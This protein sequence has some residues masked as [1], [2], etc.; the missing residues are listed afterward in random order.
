VIDRAQPAVTV[1]FNRA[2]RDPD[3]PDDA[4]LPAATL[5]ADQ[6]KP[7]L[8]AWRW[9]GTHGMMF[10]P[11]GVLPGAT[12]FAV[13]VPQ[14]AKSVEGEVLGADY[15]FEFRTDAPAVV[16]TLPVEGTTVKPD[17]TFV[18]A[19][20]QPM[21][22]AAIEKGVRVV[23]RPSASDPGR[24]VPFTAK[25]AA[26]PKDAI[27]ITPGVPL[28]LDSAVDV[29][30]DA[31]LRGEGALLA[32]APRTLSFRTY[33]P[34]R[35]ADIVCPRTSGGGRCQAHRDFTIVLSN[36]VAAEEFAAH[37]KIPGLPRHK[38]A[39]TERTTRPQGPSRE[40]LVLA[41]PDFGKRYH[42]VLTAGMRD[43][44]GQRLERDV[45]FDIDIEAPFTL[46]GQ[47]VAAPAQKGP[48]P[49]Y[50]TN[51]DEAENGDGA[52]DDGQPDTHRPRREQLQYG[53]QVG[54]TGYVLE[55]NARTGLKSHQVPVGS[56][57]IPTYAMAAAR[58]RQED[59]LSWIARADASGHAMQWPWTWVTPSAPENVRAVRTVDLDALLG[60]T[61]SHGS[62]LL[63]TAMPGSMQSPDSHVV[64]I[65]DL[66]ISARVSRYGTLV[67]VTRLSTG[68]PVA[69]ATVTIEALGKAPLF[70]G[71][72][73]ADGVLTIPA[74]QWSPMKDGAL[75]SRAVI[76][77]R[78]GDDWTFK[79]MSRAAASY[80]GVEVDLLQKADW[81][82]MIYTDRGV[83][84]PG[85]VLKLAGVFRKANAEG[86]KVVNADA[87][88]SFEDGQGE[89]VF[90][91]RADL[92][93]YGE[94]S[95]EL[96][97]P[98]TT[99]LGG[100]TVHVQI[101][102]D[103]EDRFDQSV[104]V[105]AY[106]ASEFKVEVDADRK[107]YVRGDRAKF[108]VHAEYL[109]GAP[110]ARAPL[111]TNAT[112]G[113]A[114]FVPPHSEGWVV[115]DEA[116][117]VD[118]P[119]TNA[120]AGELRAEEGLKLDE[121]GRVST[122]VG[123]DLPRMRSPETVLFEAEV[124]DVTN[125]T[126]AQRT[127]VLVHPAA[128]YV[129]LGRM[130]T[131]FVSVGAD[132]AVK[133]AAI[134]PSG[135]HVPDA[136]V[137]V[138]L[139]HR[140]WTTVIEDGPP[141]HPPHRRSRVVDDVVGH[142]DVV[143]TK[144]SGSC[145]LHVAQ[146]G[147]Y[148]VRS[149]AKDAAGNETG[150]SM[151]FYCV[152]DQADEKTTTVAWAD[153]D[154]RDL[155]LE[156][157]KRQYDANDV[158]RILV[159]NPFREAEALVT[160]ERAGVLWSKVTQLK[161][162]MPIVEVP[163]RSDYFPNAFVAV[164]LV[165]GRVQAP[166]DTGADVGGP[167]YRLGVLPIHVNP[168]THRLTIDVR[169]D[170]K[171]Y[172]PGDELDADV[173]VSVKDGKAPSSEVT[174]YAVDEGVL[175]LTAYKTPDPLPPF[176]VQRSLAV[177]PLESRESLARLIAMKNG[178]R[179]K[180]LGWEYLASA[181]EDKGSDGGGGD[182]DSPAGAGP[183]A[184]FRT[185]AFFQAG[186]V[187]SGEGNE[188]HAR[189]HFKLPDNL[190][191]FRLMAIAAS[192]DRFGAGETSITSSKHLMARPA[193]PRV[194]RVGDTFDATVVVSS[195]GM[196]P[197]LE[198]EVTLAAKGVRVIGPARKHVTLRGPSAEVHFP[199]KAEAPGEASFEMAV[200]GAGERDRV[201]VKRQVELPVAAR[202][203]AA[204]GETT[205]GAAVQLGDL[206]NARTDA[207]SGGGL[208]VHVASTAL[209]GLKTSFDRAID[210]P[211]GC[212][213]QLT[214]RVLPLLVL[215]E[216]ASLYGVRMPA[217]VADVVDDA[218]GQILTH[219]RPSGGFGFWEDDS[220]VVPWLSAYAMLAVETAGKKGFFVPK[221]ARDSGI[222]YLRRTLDSSRIE[223]TDEGDDTQLQTHA[224]ED[225]DKPATEKKARPYPTLAF[226]ADVLATLGLPD[227]GYLNRLYDARAHEPLFS[228]ALLLHAMA[229]A[230]MPRP[231]I[232]ILE[233]EVVARVR[234]TDSA[235]YVDDP[236]PGWEFLLDSSARTAAMV[237]RGI[238]AASPKD[239]LA[240]RLAK[241][242]LAHR[243][244]GAWRSTQ[245]NVWA[246]LALDDYRRAQE[247]TP[248]D[249]QA[250]VFLGDERI[251]EAAFHGFTVLDQLFTADMAR[252]VAAP[253][254]LS[255]D[256]Q[257]QGKLYYEAELR[258]ATTD[259]PEKARDR[260]FFV[261]KLVRAVAPAD[262]RAATKVLPPRSDAQ[263]PA[264]K[265][266]LVDLLLESA[267]P[268]EQVVVADPLPG[269]IE[270]VDFALDTSAVGDR[271]SLD[272]HELR[273]DRKEGYGAFKEAPGMHREMHDDQVLTFLPHLEPGIYHLHYLAR[274][275]T[276]GT[277]V[278]PP[279]RAQA[280][281]SPEV[282]GETAATQFAVTEKQ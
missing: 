185:T 169:T 177:F 100:G 245:E 168:D 204:Y 232:D 65:T 172:R 58:I 52:S 133:V 17:S 271:I 26:R 9:V 6:D 239:P 29:T 141:G 200:A 13:T 272:P 203:V 14:G 80:R 176:T 53:V 41:D 23:A 59:V 97:L 64:S 160:V 56:V 139:V 211:Y 202:T 228:Q 279:T 77:A 213:E 99:H 88:V 158:A 33:G 84:R 165:R 34:L 71:T 234:S 92:D 125:Q 153:P 108:D 173:V 35:L 264:G 69:D 263:A 235:A 86:L 36:P 191:T 63:A 258:Y 18:L 102:R 257:G 21:D 40:Q 195:K 159:R 114:Y 236:E 249:F 267:E 78:S 171:E 276:Q 274:A 32:K 74:D 54:L 218:V 122:S 216:M 2:M 278:V 163:V 48:A 117:V 10:L 164:H 66:A 96:P 109:F 269:G 226:A 89:K 94:L 129:G 181:G 91:G 130:Q 237:L 273:T 265:L 123:L 155:K 240:E 113:R 186:Q 135:A 182:D 4:G 81:A 46:A 93:A 224:D 149:R 167:E 162:P 280:M 260:G 188:G 31:G 11:A 60:G 119:E 174:F 30:V 76:F 50:M 152:D 192:G 241:G 15:H 256:V 157:D 39:A 266:V 238:V 120:S 261:R 47:P 107:E 7:V 194:V 206:K 128:F 222:E 229:A 247:A 193:L 8:G 83:Y 233:K 19:F 132:A 250:R 184:D 144:D 131:S 251:G 223:A 244:D 3:A 24:P 275:T 103:V 242:L 175:M 190:T 161:G 126:V 72:T 199:V 183:R 145:K 281:Y 61:G 82:G 143:T 156:A 146:A 151:S 111:K 230:R 198:A 201:L 90:D 142:C 187:T 75:D 225:E 255:F 259:L 124:Q 38:P 62:A 217:K 179:I 214:S 110:M 231:Q 127:S 136:R 79:G 98:K 105:A 246:L 55:A 277:F 45:P 140:M 68:A 121:D 138:D 44:L 178:D 210:Y 220:E 57:N 205:T 180:P 85:E 254:P 150:S 95:L 207:A 51:D 42:A 170:K 189:Y 215:P 20:N 219:Q 118:H 252:I 147:Y 262:L 221:A 67:W 28:P 209:V 25:R 137:G 115:S 87:R 243:V 197:T 106:K 116:G 208:E 268:Q 22:P 16:E 73:N 166:P 154:S 37:L 112:R 70:S 248:P 134:A 101:G 196:A 5:V 1:L 27:A 49:R 282:W 270:P 12:R 253:G 227:P 104:L 43:D 148:I 212:T